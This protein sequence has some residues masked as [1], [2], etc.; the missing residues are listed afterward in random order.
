MIGLSV[1]FSSF[2]TPKGSGTISAANLKTTGASPSLPIVLRSLTPAT[3]LAMGSSSFPG[4]LKD[5]TVDVCLPNFLVV[6]TS[7]K[8]FISPVTSPKVSIFHAS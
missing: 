7:G 5:F 2:C 8:K 6:N 4:E 1:Y 3:D